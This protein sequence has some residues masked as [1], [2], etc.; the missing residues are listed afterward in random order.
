VVD[1][2]Q[3]LGVLPMDVKA[4]SIDAVVAD[5]HKWLLGPEGAGIMAITPK[6]REQLRPVISGWRNVWL[7]HGD[8]FLERLEHHSDGRRFEPGAANDVGV[9]G[10]AAGLDLVTSIETGLIQSRVEMLSR[11]LT[12]ILISHGWDV[13]SPGAGHPIAG[14]VAARHRNVA[15]AEAARRLGERRVVCSV[16]QGYLRLSPHFYITRGELEALDRILEKVGL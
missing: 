11:T 15:P 6:L 8:F 10:L 2:I 7:A 9:A 1:A 12:R 16:R 5:G 3:G 4:M 13:F 14:I